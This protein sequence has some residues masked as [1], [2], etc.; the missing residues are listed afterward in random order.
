M[1]AQHIRHSAS[2][3]AHYYVALLQAGGPLFFIQITTYELSQSRGM[4]SRFQSM[5]RLLST[6]IYLERYLCTNFYVCTIESS[7]LLCL[8]QILRNSSRFV[9]I[10]TFF[11]VA[12]LSSMRPFA[13]LKNFLVLSTLSPSCGQARLFITFLDA[14]TC[15]I[16]NFLDSK[17]TRLALPSTRPASVWTQ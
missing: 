4:S 2:A 1:A 3:S 13:G 15:G 5:H 16:K 11:H 14:A 6:I 12:T 17:N 7:N 9:L 8:R 10:Y